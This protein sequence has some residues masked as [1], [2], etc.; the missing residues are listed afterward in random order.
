MLDSKVKQMIEGKSE[1]TS[2]DI[3]HLQLELL[4][5]RDNIQGANAR[6]ST[7][8]WRLGLAENR[9]R[10]MTNAV[11]HRDEMLDSLTWKA[12]RVVL[13][14]LSPIRYVLKRLQPSKSQ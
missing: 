13:W 10:S 4:A 2:N 6:A 11:K 1:F 5:L 8:E 3:Q 12:G 14:P 9:I 7:A